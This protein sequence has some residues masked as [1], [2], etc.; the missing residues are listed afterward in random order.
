MET[1]PHNKVN[2]MDW[3]E[4]EGRLR[5]PATRSTRGSK[6]AASDERALRDYYGDEE[7]EYLQKLASHSGL[8]RSRA[9]ILGNVVFLPGIMGSNLSARKGTD[10]G[11]IWINLLRIVSGRIERLRLS[12]DGQNNFDPSYTVSTDAVD[13]RTYTRAILWLRARWNVEPFPFDWRRDIDLAS[14]ELA[15]FIREKFSGKPVHLVAH[16]MGGLVCRN[17]IRLNRD[18]WEQMR[19]EDGTRGGRLIML[20]TPN[21]GSYTIPQVLTGIEPL[22]KWLDRIDFQHNRAELQEIINSFVG[23]YQMLPAPARLSPAAQSLYRRS[24]WG[25]FPIS[26]LHL[27]RAFQ[28]H[29]DLEK[30][31]TIDPERMIYIAG[32]GRP[33]LGG[34]RIISPGE[35]EY[36]ITNNGDGRVSHELGLLKGVTTY[37]AD[38]GHGDLPRNQ[39]VMGAVDELLERGLTAAL[40]QQPIAAR[41]LQAE[42]AR[43][44]RSIGTREVELDLEAIAARAE[45]NEATP[46]E[47]RVAEESLQRQVLGREQATERLPQVAARQEETARKVRRNHLH[48]KAMRG[49]ITRVAAPMVVVGHYQGV[50]PTSAEKAIDE[51][52][53]YWISRA[54][55]NGMIGAGL[56]QLFFIPV[57]GPG[58]QLQAK[59]VLLA[60]MGDP[61]AL[62]RD[63]LRYLTM[64][65][66]LAISFLGHKSFATVAMGSGKGSLTIE[67]S[68]RGMLQG[69]CDA[70]QRLPEGIGVKEIILAEFDPMRYAQILEVLEKFKEQSPI[71]ELTITYTTKELPSTR[72]RERQ[73]PRDLLPADEPENRITI[74][75]A[76]DVFRFSAMGAE[77][78]IPVREVEVQSAFATS[79]AE[80]LMLAEVEA[81]QKKYGSLLYSYLIPQDFHQMIDTDRPLTLVLDR[82]TASFPWE[83]ASFTGQRG[84]TYLG[85][86][87]KLTRQ[88]RT[89]L[90]SAPGIAPQRNRNI[91][92]LVIA[93]PA[94]EPTYQLPGA[95]N[96]GRA[97]AKIFNEFKQKRQLNIELVERIGAAECDPVE[98]LAL[99]LN[100][101]FDI[102]HYA[103]HG[104]FDE[105]NPNKSGWV[106]GENCVISAT[107]IFR[108]RRVPRLVFA[109]ACFSAVVTKDKSSSAEQVNRQLAGMAEAFFER[110]VQNYLGAGWPVADVQGV[111]F[112]ETFYSKALSGETLGESIA[113]AR[114]SILGQGSTWGA[115]HHYGQANTTLI[116]DE[117]A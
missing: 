117:G 67:R 48:I 39:A 96:E 31:N 60:G 12:A 110:G 13:K 111:T 83:M 59:A 86:N 41:A 8:V 90:S 27:Q 18:L 75:R 91:K 36:T 92:A 105:Q 74:E 15:R 71:E 107:E 104:I 56:G 45:R 24:T 63:D 114:L 76:G 9:P 3:D 79:A 100:E 4:L 47:L 64:N 2:A 21:Y 112:A 40:P 33:T 73:R 61:G 11:V 85:P 30:D 29:D 95:R 42:G 69:A 102:I 97:V 106:F 17:L 84:T 55:E 88:F 19:G 22:V 44:Y 23:S 108:A 43:W 37:Y 65:V 1:Q 16:S 10:E 26:E 68:L 80:R 46:E 53:N 103:G 14:K 57:Q 94:P 58:A 52:T 49:D 115:Y 109:N 62:R 50:A 35:F 28:F 116:S 51:A 25:D 34:L 101:N 32:S 5:Q 54:G 98:I 89:M 78:V 38:E 82:Q 6:S 20:G 87:L 66:T 113:A 77:A 93:D 7:Y 72:K 70:L 81:E 99:I